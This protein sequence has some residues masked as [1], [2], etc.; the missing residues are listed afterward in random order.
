MAGG[1]DEFP[2][3]ITIP[4]G[5]GLGCPGRRA[6]IAAAPSASSPADVAP[7]GGD[8]A[9]DVL[10]FMAVLID[11]GLPGPRATDID[12]SGLVDVG[13]FLAVLNEWTG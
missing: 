12:G 9:V 4:I 10:D 8:G 3:V 13:D 6:T 7:A 2:P 5:D 11:W 1:D